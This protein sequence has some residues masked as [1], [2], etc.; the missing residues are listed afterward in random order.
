MFLGTTMMRPLVAHGADDARLAVLP[1]HGAD[2]CHLAQTRADAV[3][4]DQQPGFK[5]DTVRQMHHR[6]GRSGLEPFDADTLDDVDAQFGRA[7]AQRTVEVTV[8]DHVREW[9]AWSH[10]AI[11][12]EEDRANGI[13]RPGVRHDHLRDRLG[14]G[15]QLVP[16]PEARQHA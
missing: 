16:D 6:R 14:L 10:F 11:E 1:V 2:A 5:G 15:K 3:G 9:F 7:S 13:G 12:G 8:H 4:G